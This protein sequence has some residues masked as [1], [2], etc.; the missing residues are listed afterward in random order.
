MKTIS[1]FK[2][3]ADETRIR[4]MNLLVRHELNVN[5]IVS[6]MDMGQ[7]RISR[8]LKILTD[9]GLLLSR[10]DGLWVFYRA[11]DSGRGGELVECFKKIIYS[12]QSMKQDLKELDYLLKERARE[13]TRFF[14]SLAP[15]WDSIKSGL[16]G[17]DCV[18][19]D[20]FAL[21]EPCDIIADLGCGTGL[22]IPYLKEKTNRV[23]GVDRS[24]RMLEQ[25]R[26]NC[27]DIQDGIDFR[28]GELEHLPMR[29][30]EADAAVISMVLHYL[31]RPFE[32]IQEAARVVKRR[33]TLI[34][35]DLDK[36]S[37]EDMRHRY[38]HRWLGFSVDEIKS[39]LVRAGFSVS[40]TDE[41]HIQKGLRMNFFISKR[42]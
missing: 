5:E 25:A 39:W 29:E 40:Q 21:L 4:L 41:R 26:T 7:S 10:R 6:L 20:F 32:A 17:D 31:A 11:A 38:G 34:V 2:A 30:H 28:I 1:F 24:P 12:D 22:L 42:K 8:H 3:L 33:G 35:V 18:T 16:V 37:N 19:R 23:I 15:Q 9:S 13:K 36:H 27:K 14:D